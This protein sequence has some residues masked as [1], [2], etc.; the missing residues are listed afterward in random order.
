MT[1]N[2]LARKA[3]IS[4]TMKA[5]ALLDLEPAHVVRRRRVGR[6]AEERGEAPDV[7]DI[8]ALG[9]ARKAPHVHVFDQPLTQRADRGGGKDKGISAERTVKCDE[10][11]GAGPTGNDQVLLGGVKSVRWASRLFRKVSMPPR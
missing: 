5:L 9:G 2:A 4:R 1:F 10:V 6:P 7:A 11:F 8:V 3:A